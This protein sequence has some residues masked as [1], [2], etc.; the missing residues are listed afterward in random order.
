MSSPL[1]L[2]PP[3]LRPLLVVVVVVVVVLLPPGPPPFCI[4]CFLAFFFF[5]F[6]FSGMSKNVPRRPRETWASMRLEIAHGSDLSGIR[7]RL[8]QVSEAK[9]VAASR[10]TSEVTPKMSRERS[11][12]R[13]C[14]EL[15]T[16]PLRALKSCFVRCRRSSSARRPARRE[17]I[18]GSQTPALTKG[19]HLSASPMRVARRS[20]CFWIALLSVRTRR[21]TQIPGGH[22]S[23]RVAPIPMRHGTPRSRHRKPMD[24]QSVI[25][26]DQVPQCMAG[27][28]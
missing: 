18:N 19:M 1:Q 17:A 3:P 10:G 12:A 6:C 13:I 22:D 20:R 16:V 9:A 26:A 4:F 2:R 7:S 23:S 21:A 8:N 25:A 11:G 28:R 15:T 27:T 14:A 5:F 24:T